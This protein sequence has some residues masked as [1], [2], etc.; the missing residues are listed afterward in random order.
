VNLAPNLGGVGEVAG[1]P[2]AGDGGGR[3]E[4][5]RL[6]R[7]VGGGECSDAARE[8]PAPGHALSGDR[9]EREG[10][11]RRQSQRSC[12][13]AWRRGVEWSRTGRGF[14]PP[15]PYCLRATLR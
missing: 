11:E 7:A 9:G 5:L 15:V 12:G 1:V 6:D 4:P 14:D 8:S 10:G 3:Q 13:R 2:G